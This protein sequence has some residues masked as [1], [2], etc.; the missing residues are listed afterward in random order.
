MDP[1][2]LWPRIRIGPHPTTNLILTVV[3]VGKPSL[4]MMGNSLKIPLV[5]NRGRASKGK[6]RRGNMR[7]EGKTEGG[8]MWKADSRGVC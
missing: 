6:R 4:L 2:I 7:H 5:A 1:N 8:L 3:D